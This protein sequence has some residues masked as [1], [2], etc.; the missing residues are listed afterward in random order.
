MKKREPVERILLTGEIHGQGYAFLGP[1]ALHIYPDKEMREL[2]PGEVLPGIVINRVEAASLVEVI[3]IWLENP[4]V[5][6]S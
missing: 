4:P 5:I 3:R 6:T 1:G 2:N